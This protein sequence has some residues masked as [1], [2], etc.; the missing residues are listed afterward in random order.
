MTRRNFGFTNIYM[1][2]GFALMLSGALLLG[3]LL[4]LDRSG[5]AG[6]GGWMIQLSFVLFAG[7][8]IVYLIGRI[9][10]ALNALRQP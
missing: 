1:K 6:F 4:M 10:K 5:S 3:V 9:A 8:V 2:L 7:G